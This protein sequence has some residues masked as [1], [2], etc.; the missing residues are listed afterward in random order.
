MRRFVER[1]V[2]PK[3][4]AWPR[5]S[6]HAGARRGGILRHAFALAVP[7]IRLAVLTL[8]AAGG[9]AQTAAKVEFEVASVRPS[10]P[11][12]QGVALTVGCKGGPGTGDPTHLVCSNM[13][14]T[15][16][17][18][19]AYGITNVQ[20]A[21]PE[22][23]LATR[24]DLNANLPPAATREQ[25]MEMLRNLLAE[26]FHLEVHHE[27]RE[28]LQFEL[29]VAKNGPKLHPAPQSERPPGGGN[30]G[31]RRRDVIYLHFRKRTWRFSHR[32]GAPKRISL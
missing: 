7:V 15:L 22:W 18:I 27:A 17:F 8:V 12:G 13:S 26:R 4:L 29:V 10:A 14:A 3:W 23:L 16:L 6:W 24:F 19:R 20:L 2:R 5:R 11:P 28:T 25:V 1:V 30:I 9:I 21:G 32:L 31:R